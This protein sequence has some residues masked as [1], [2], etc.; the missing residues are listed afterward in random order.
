M[1]PE[2]SSRLRLEDCGDVLT[3]RDCAAVTGMSLNGT[4]EALRRG[5]LPGIRVGRKWL[6]PKARLLSLLGSSQPLEP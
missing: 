1:V 5:E 6:I 3:V 4:Y 2:R